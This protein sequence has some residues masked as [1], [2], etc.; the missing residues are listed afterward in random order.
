MTPNPNEASELAK[1]LLKHCGDIELPIKPWEYEAGHLMRK[2][3]AA[4]LDR[5]A[6]DEGDDK[7][8]SSVVEIYTPSEWEA[9]WVGVRHGKGQPRSAAPD[10][11]RVIDTGNEGGEFCRECG[12]YFGKHYPSCPTLWE[13]NGPLGNDERFVRRSL[14]ESEAAVN[15]ALGL[16]TPRDASSAT[17]EAVAWIDKR[18]LEYFRNSGDKQA[19]CTAYADP[20]G[21]TDGGVALFVHPAQQQRTPDSE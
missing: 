17:S 15:A 19:W 20:A 21:T 11:E 14:P 5:R 7:M 6:T 9:Y 3:A 18:D 16:S 10:G 1:A 13:R 4:L 12:K 2:A 8:I